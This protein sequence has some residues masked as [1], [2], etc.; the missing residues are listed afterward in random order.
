MRAVC[1]RKLGGVCE[2]TLARR[3]L[4]RSRVFLHLRKARL[5]GQRLA[6]MTE[7]CELEQ[8]LGEL[9]SRSRAW[10]ENS[11]VCQFG[12]TMKQ[13]I[14]VRCCRRVSRRFLPKLG[15]PSQM[16]GSPLR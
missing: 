15:G 2:K 16:A 13:R 10:D 12:R 14:S 1:T 4:L 9:S 11:W 5:R 8:A 6:Q 7:P 3:H